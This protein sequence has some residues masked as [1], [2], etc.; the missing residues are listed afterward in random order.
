MFVSIDVFQQ[1]TTALSQ[2]TVLNLMKYQGD[3]KPAFKTE[4]YSFLV[5]LHRVQSATYIKSLVPQF[6]NVWLPVL[7]LCTVCYA[8]WQWDMG[9]GCIHMLRGRGC[10]YMSKNESLISDGLT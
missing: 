2:W 7:D 6:Q 10:A 9:R 4:C 1:N 8:I 5:R 3:L